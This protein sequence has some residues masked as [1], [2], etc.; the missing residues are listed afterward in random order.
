MLLTKVD[1]VSAGK[2]IMVLFVINCPVVTVGEDSGGT[3]E[4]SAAAQI[5]M[6][7]RSAT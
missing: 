3:L 7:K 1:T 6:L 4:F 2:T 5:V